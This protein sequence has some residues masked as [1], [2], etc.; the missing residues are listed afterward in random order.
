ME[1]SKNMPDFLAMTIEFMNRSNPITPENA[2]LN[3]KDGLYYCKKCHTPREVIEPFPVPDG[4][5]L[6]HNR[7]CDCDVA[8][9][10]AEKK[11]EEERKK[12]E[13][14]ISLRYD[15]FPSCK[16]SSNDNS[17]RNW[18]FA[19]DKGYQPEIRRKALNF[20]EDFDTWRK[21]GK[22]LLFYGDVGTGKSYMAA[23]IANALIDREIPVLMT[24]FA[25]IANTVWNIQDK[26]GY[27]ESLN[28]YP[29]LIIDDLG[30]QRENR[31]MDE[32][33][34]NVINMRANSGLPLIVTTN[35]SAREILSE[36]TK[37]GKR[38][39]SRL[40]RMCVMVEVKGADLRQITG[41]DE[42][43]EFTALLN[44]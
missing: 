39:F 28:R 2:Y 22:G 27:Y 21:G 31:Y 9:Q 17:M 11:R 14:I 25:T 8:R 29:L 19:N 12:A 26:Q 35:L 41:F 43:A 37:G 20:V 7:A 38:I 4:R 23:C 34:F 44:K 36:E 10:E 40:T 3:S 24:D 16:Q 33:V 30:V 32:I 6:K 13:H 5:P 15:A 18:T 1:N 42:M